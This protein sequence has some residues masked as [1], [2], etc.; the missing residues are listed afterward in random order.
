MNIINNENR[1]MYRLIA[2]FILVLCGAVW[3][4]TS[5][6]DVSHKVERNMSMLVQ[7]HLPELDSIY[8]LQSHI[9]SLGLILYNYYETTDSSDYATKW[10]RNQQNTHQLLANLDHDF[11]RDVNDYLDNLNTIADD[12]DTEMQHPQ[13]DWDVLRNY[14]AVYSQ[15][16]DEFD[17]MLNIHIQSLQD[18]FKYYSDNTESLIAKMVISQMVF[19]GFVIVF[20]LVFAFVLKRMLQQHRINRELALYPE[21][22]PNPILRLNA[23][24]QVVYLNPSAV[25]LAQSLNCAEFPEKLLPDTDSQSPDKLQGRP[26][27]YQSLNYPLGNKLFSA[28][29][30]H[31]DQDDSVYAYL[32]DVTDRVKAENELL[33]RSNHDLL[34]GLPNRRK[35]EE[36]L[37][38][39]TQ[40]SLNPFSLLFIKVSRLDLI[41]ASLGHEISDKVLQAM[42]HRLALFVDKQSEH[43]LNLYSFESTSWVIIYNNTATP[44]DAK[45]LGDDVVGLFLSPLTI[46]DGELSMQCMVGI[47]TYPQDGCYSDELLRNADAALRQG[48]KEALAVRLYSEDLTEQATRSLYLEQGL[49]QALKKGEF[50]LNIQPKVDAHSQHIIGGEVLIRWCYNDVFI[51]PAE[52]I[53]IAEESDLIIAIGEWVLLTSCKQW[54]TWHDEGLDPKKIAVNISAQHFIQAEFVD[55]VHHVLT[56]STIPPAAL[57]LE[58]TEEVASVNPEKLIKTMMELKQLGVSLAI[59]DFGTGYSSLSYLMQFPLDTLKI[60]KSFVTKMTN[61]ENDA[62]LVRMIMSLAKELKLAVVAEGVE[63]EQQHKALA[64]LGCEYIQG[65][66]FYRP[67]PLDDYRTLLLK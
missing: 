28:I 57:E 18:S 26:I 64:D 24:G 13:T 54:V 34:T 52:F 15:I 22:N 23:T 39:K 11:A 4:I 3:I 45:A 32:L 61:S 50:S 60:D 12:F 53:P 19:S 29:F 42:S 63:T 46:G 59:D 17:V 5:L 36:T 43:D 31:T 14:L 7:D 20:L 40:A 55:Y 10:Q 38:S 65:Y 51:S 56:L 1:V 37:T 8:T 44:A 9:K 6:A 16:S 25:A 48:N 35:L 62:A 47:T 30:N 2:A 58:I 66:H 67:M 49:K 21:R 33:H 41:N 27:N